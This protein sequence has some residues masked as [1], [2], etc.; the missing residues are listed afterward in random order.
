MIK[1]LFAKFIAERL[2]DILKK[3]G[4]LFFDGNKKYNLNI[5]GI[6]NDSHDSTKFD[7]TLLLIYRSKSL[8]WEVKSYEVTTEPGPAILRKPINQKGTAVLVPGQYRG[9]YKIDTHGSK[10][11]HTALCQRLGKVK[12]YRDTDKDSK[13]ETTGVIEEGMF[14]INIHRHARLGEKEYVGGSSA[15]CQVFKDSKQFAEFMEL[16]NTSADFFDNSFTY[17]LITEEDLY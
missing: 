2:E 12:V 13:P 3:K 14:G 16:C 10:N 9:T 8:D 6:R 15:G 7:D 5:I 17:T 11:R 4:Y 1:N